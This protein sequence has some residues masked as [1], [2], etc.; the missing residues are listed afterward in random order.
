MPDITM[1]SGY[2]FA[3]GKEGEYCPLAGTCYRRQA[4]PAPDQKPYFPIAPFDLVGRCEY[5]IATEG[6]TL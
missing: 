1:C 3:D 2:K 6:P 4:K 5:F